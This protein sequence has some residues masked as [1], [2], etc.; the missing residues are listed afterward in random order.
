MAR[1]GQQTGRISVNVTPEQE[2]AFNTMLDEMVEFRKNL[3]AQFPVTWSLL[4]RN[5]ILLDMLK[6]FYLDHYSRV[7][8]W[9]EHEKQQ[10]KRTDLKG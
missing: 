7:A 1:K 8:D 3:H 5:D 10:G 2:T 6:K 4:S 9:P